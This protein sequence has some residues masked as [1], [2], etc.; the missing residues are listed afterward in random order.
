[1]FFNG[2]PTKGA[3]PGGGGHEAA[4]F[5]FTLPHDAPT[6]DRQDQW[7]FCHKCN[8]MFFDGFPTKGICQ[9]GGGHEA[10]GFTF[11]LNHG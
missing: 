8:A 7:R 6:S 10:A 4:G 11:V 1:M 2:F 5:N 9:S 3:C